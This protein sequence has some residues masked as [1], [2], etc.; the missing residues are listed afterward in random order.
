MLVWYRSS[1]WPQF[2]VQMNDSQTV[3]YNS[4]DVYFY[5]AFIYPMII[6]GPL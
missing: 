3:E 5:I 1:Y 4:E 6:R 2:S